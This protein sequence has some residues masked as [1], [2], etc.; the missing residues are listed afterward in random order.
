ML[1]SPLTTA[2]QEG[3][4]KSSSLIDRFQ[5]ADSSCRNT[6]TEILAAIKDKGDEALLEYTRKFDAPK[7]TAEQLRVTDAEMAA[8]YNQIDDTL[9]ASLQ[10]AKNRIQDFHEREMEES[11][12]VT[13]ED[14][15]ITG[16]LVRPVASAG[17]YVPG[18][19]GGKTPLVSS[20]STSSSLSIFVLLFL[21]VAPPMVV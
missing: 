21:S 15:T 8:A 11:W 4:E 2:S 5:L 9:M 18:G 14:G 19:Q 3:K 16:R 7:M 20:T 13:R 1:I 17:L 12:I 6:V 10:L